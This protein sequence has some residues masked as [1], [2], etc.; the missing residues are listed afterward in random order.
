M[1]QFPPPVRGIHASLITQLHP[2]QMGATQSQHHYPTNHPV[3]Q[4]RR[5]KSPASESNLDHD[6]FWR[7]TTIPRLRA[8]QGKFIV[9]RMPG[10]DDDCSDHRPAQ[11]TTNHTDNLRLERAQ[12]ELGRKSKSNGDNAPSANLSKKQRSAGKL[13]M[14]DGKNTIK[15]VLINIFFIVL[16]LFL[17]MS[18]CGIG[19]NSNQE[20][21]DPPLTSNCT[22]R[23]CPRRKPI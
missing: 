7:P 1:S 5:Q 19:T 18:A 6:Q 2:R 3:K 16:L 9:P 15:Y 20:A 8:S 14:P 17:G 22:T 11:Q 4:R 13:A 12:A 10:A 21:K 23:N